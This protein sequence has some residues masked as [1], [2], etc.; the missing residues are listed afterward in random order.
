MFQSQPHQDWLDAGYK[1][2][3]TAPIEGFDGYLS[4]KIRDDSGVRYIIGVFCRDLGDNFTYKPEIQVGKGDDAF[5]IML[6]LGHS[7]QHVE[8][9]FAEFW[10]RMNLKHLEIEVG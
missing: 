3:P 2:S 1:Y 4:K 6:H 10:E 9:A 5:T 8:Q 7:P